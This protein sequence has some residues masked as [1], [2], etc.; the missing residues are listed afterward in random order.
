MKFGLFSMNTGCCTYPDNARQ[1]AHAAESAGF[2]SLWV[3][4]HI[5]LP[6]PPIDRFPTPSDSR[7]MESLIML[8]FLAAQTQKVKLGTGV[9]VLPQREPL[10]LAKQ[11]ASVDELSKGRL[12]FGF[13][14]GHLQPELEAIGIPFNERGARSDEYLSAMLT[15][16]QDAKPAFHGKHVSF[17]NIQSHPQREIPIVVG[18]YAPAALRRTIQRAHGWYGFSKTVAETKECLA[19]LRQTATEVE[20]PA[21]LG[22]LEISLTPPRGPIDRAMVE[23]YAEI[24]VHRLVLLPTSDEVE[25]R[26]SFVDDVEEIISA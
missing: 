6:E 18:G 1:I 17:A 4:D 24:G 23:Q 21:H 2:E 3:S 12:I 10:V 13:G 20:R 16:W 25:G 22:E 5:V 11:L 9:I 15:L 14:V 8:S 19:D 26:L 7:I